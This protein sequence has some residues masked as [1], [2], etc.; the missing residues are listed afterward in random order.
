MRRE[1]K[2]P[3]SSLEIK[4]KIPAPYCENGRIVVN[5]EWFL[6]GIQAK[7][8]LRHELAHFNVCPVSVQNH[9]RY[10]DITRDILKKINFLYERDIELITSINNIVYDFVVEI[11]IV[12]EL[13]DDLLHRLLLD[14]KVIKK[15]NKGKFPSHF[16]WEVLAQF[17][18][19]LV[20]KKVLKP[21]KQKALD[22]GNKLFEIM[23]TNLHFEKKLALCV[24]LLAEQE[25]MKDREEL[26]EFLEMLGRA[27]HKNFK[28]ASVRTQLKSKREAK[29]EVKESI[30]IKKGVSI[31]RFAIGFAES[32]GVKLND[33]DY[34][35]AMAQNNI[36][37]RLKLAAGSSGAEVRGHFDVWTL[38]SEP[39]RL[40]LEESFFESPILIP[41]QTTLMV[42]RKK[43]KEKSKDVPDC[44]LVVDT[45]A[46]MDYEDTL[47]TVFSF[48]LSCKNYGVNVAVV[49]F[50]TRAYLEEEFSLDY[51]L[52]MR[53]V[54]D[55]YQSGG[56]ITPTGAVSAE[57]ILSRWKT[58]CLIIFISDFYCYRK[59][60]T[61]KK[62]NELANNN[63]VV[64]VV[65][66]GG[67]HITENE[68]GTLKPK[69]VNS[70]EELNNIIIGEV[71]SFV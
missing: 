70:I 14:V 1:F 48:I 12:K 46:S 30:P 51:T 11:Y 8:I 55:E 50:S 68:L 44:L 43:G 47:L 40:D 35:V 20:K 41:E 62:L 22:V 36:S 52:K 66:G 54:Y 38:D 34:Y 59:A 45:S 32:V 9:R 28:K 69:Y 67:S 63:F 25:F 42:E 64:P 24:K 33:F 4:K 10:L 19:R 13:N 18:N 39:D 57:T 26:M 53:R 37:F 2:F 61:F 29:E 71:S 21:L 58:G 16:L 15:R 60:E 56:T 31:K 3:P 23:G 27:L 17:Y 6:D 5:N 49:L 7:S 65:F